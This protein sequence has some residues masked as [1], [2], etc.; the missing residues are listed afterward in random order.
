MKKVTLTSLLVHVL[1]MVLTLSGCV[2]KDVVETGAMQD[3]LLEEYVEEYTS[4]INRYDT[5]EGVFESESSYI[6]MSDAF[7]ARILYPVTGNEEMDRVIEEYVR[8]LAA[9]HSKE[10]GE[11][12]DKNS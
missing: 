5:P 4:E 12:Y 1:I 10:A 7:V 6:M 2:Q 3:P 8:E 9:E 11:N